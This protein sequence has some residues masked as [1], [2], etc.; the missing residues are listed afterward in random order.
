VADVIISTLVISPRKPPVA[1]LGGA[2]LFV[3]RNLVRPRYAA[4]NDEGARW[5][6]LPL[7]LLSCI[8]SSQAPISRT[9]Q[10]R[11]RFLCFKSTSNNYEL[12]ILRRFARSPPS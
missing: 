2:S 12:A 6:V 1:P 7:L 3:N 11:F 9:N 4:P 10:S 8:L 5:R